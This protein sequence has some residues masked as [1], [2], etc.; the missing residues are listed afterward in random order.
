MDAGQHFMLTMGL[1]HVH[2]YKQNFTKRDGFEIKYKAD[3]LD[4][5]R[6]GSFALSVKNRGPV[7]SLEVKC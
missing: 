5:A 3:G 2:L 7:P 1:A 6:S 4:M